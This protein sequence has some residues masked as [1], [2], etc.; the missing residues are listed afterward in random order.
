ME[1]YSKDSIYSRCEC[2]LG[3]DAGPCLRR[4][5]GSSQ[6]KEGRGVANVIPN[7]MRD[8]SIFDILNSYSGIEQSRL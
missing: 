7:E 3:K 1:R 4:D 6:K 8:P 2:V 5:D